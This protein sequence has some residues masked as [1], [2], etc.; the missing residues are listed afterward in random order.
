MPR[1]HTI[2]RKAYK[3]CVCIAPHPSA[4][5]KSILLVLVLGVPDAAKPILRVVLRHWPIRDTLHTLLLLEL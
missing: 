3:P 2:L 5:E 1:V 4:C